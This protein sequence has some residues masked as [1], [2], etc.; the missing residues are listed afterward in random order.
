MIGSDA[1]IFVNGQVQEYYLG[2]KSA[3]AIVPLDKQEL[4]NTAFS[5]SNGKTVVK[6]T[7]ALKS[8]QAN[9]IVS[10]VLLCDACYA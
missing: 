1:V 7:R 10:C 4:T 9:Q 6:F 5:Q 2:D 8:N 3:S